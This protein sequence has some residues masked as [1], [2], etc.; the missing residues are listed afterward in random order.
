MDGLKKCVQCGKELVDPGTGG[1]KVFCSTR[2]RVASHRASLKRQSHAMAHH[3]KPPW[4][5]GKRQAR[6]KKGAAK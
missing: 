3:S 6:P 1:R 5:E 4:A 2:C